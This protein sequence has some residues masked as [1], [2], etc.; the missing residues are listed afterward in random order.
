LL[1]L[2]AIGPALWHWGWKS[3]LRHKLH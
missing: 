1:K 2:L 3:M